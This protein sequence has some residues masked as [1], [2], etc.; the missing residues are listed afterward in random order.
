IGETEVNGVEFGI[1]GKI[2]DRWEVA[3]GYTYLDAELVDDG[4]GGN[5]GNQVKYIAPHSFSLWTT[6][7]LTDYF[8]IGGGA[9]YMSERFIDDANTRELPSHWRF[10]AMAAYQVTENIGL[11]LNINN[12]TNET[13]YDASHVG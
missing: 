2:T 1:T 8:K 11:Q 5:D 6:Y 13:Y 7:A 4:A 10:D 12:I 3:G 9:Y